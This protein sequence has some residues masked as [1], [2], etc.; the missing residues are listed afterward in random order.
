MTF[1]QFLEIFDSPANL[2]WEKE[3]R[4]WFSKPVESPL[5]RAKFSIENQNYIFDARITLLKD[6]PRLLKLLKRNRIELNPDFKV[7]EISFL[8]ETETGLSDKI[9][10]TGNASKV[11]GTVL[12]AIQQTIQRNPT[13]IV[14]FES[15]ARDEGRTRLYK[16]M[17]QKFVRNYRVLEL[18]VTPYAFV[19]VK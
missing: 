16:R 7:T 14:F 11:F 1:K 2:T 10:N 3:K 12:S 5:K 18:P 9:D 6:N 19:L 13:D 17:C 8:H 4:G 15:S